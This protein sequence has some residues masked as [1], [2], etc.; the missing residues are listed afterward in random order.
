MSVSRWPPLGT[1]LWDLR[2]TAND[3]VVSSIWGAPV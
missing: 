1:F 2:V 3:G